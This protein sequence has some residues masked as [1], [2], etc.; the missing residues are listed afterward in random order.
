MNILRKFRFG[1]SFF[2]SQ[3]V[4]NDGTKKHMLERP[5]LIVENLLGADESMSSSLEMLCP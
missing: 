3:H 2:S 1:Y 5:F 4:S